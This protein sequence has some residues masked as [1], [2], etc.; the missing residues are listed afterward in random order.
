MSDIETLSALEPY[1]S[2]IVS[3]VHRED[4]FKPNWE[5]SRKILGKNYVSMSYL[6]HVDGDDYVVSVGDNQ[7]LPKDVPYVL[8]NA[9]NYDMYA[10]ETE[11]SQK[12]LARNRKLYPLTKFFRPLY[13]GHVTV[14]S[15]DAYDVYESHGELSRGMVGYT[16]R[17]GKNAILHETGNFTEDPDFFLRAVRA[18]N[19]ANRIDERSHFTAE[20]EQNHAEIHKPIIT[21]LEQ[22]V[23][24]DGLPAVEALARYA[25]QYEETGDISRDIAMTLDISA[26]LEPALKTHTMFATYNLGEGNHLLIELRG[27]KKRSSVKAVHDYIFDG[28]TV[29]RTYEQPWLFPSILV[30]DKPHKG[31]TN[32]EHHDKRLFTLSDSDALELNALIKQL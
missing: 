22:L 6:A 27:N 13:E 23:M 4:G 2:E 5:R 20:E 14:S 17:S 15:R 7:M 21:R 8:W 32:F 24:R 18:V 16:L 10:T 26:Q 31:I 19:P 30:V 12:W 29:T 28:E 1:T 3:V 9:A 11:A 25:D